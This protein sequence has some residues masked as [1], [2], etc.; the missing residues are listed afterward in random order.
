MINTKII[1][2]TAFYIIKSKYSL[3]NYFEWIQNFIHIAKSMHFGLVIYT[4]EYSKSM[5]LKI[6]NIEQYKNIII[7]IKPIEEFY[8]YQYNTQ[9][10]NNHIK[11]ELLN[12]KIHW[13]IN[14]LWN[15]KVNFVKNTAELF[16]NAEYY[17]WC[18]IGYF[19]QRTNDLSIISLK[20]WSNIYKIRNVLK[21]NKIHYSCIL[22]DNNNLKLLCKNINTKNNN[23]LPIIPIPPDQSSI[24]GGFFILPKNKID[25]WVDTYNA[26]VKLYFTHN[27]LIKDDQIILADCIFSNL[28]MFTLHIE[29]NSQ[30]DNWFMFQRILL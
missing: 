13:S 17:G 3:K 10:I 28:N 8:N 27:Y 5:L 9:W 22:N 7:I 15:E 20:N 29:N 1:Y 24:A 23:N 21:D 2:T 16:P 11:N 12:Q 30:F 6:N 26:K 4:N 25:W 14:M 19:R 18:D